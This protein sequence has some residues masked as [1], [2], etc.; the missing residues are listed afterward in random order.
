MSPTRAQLYD[1]PVPG[2]LAP[3]LSERD[4]VQGRADA[5]FELVM[6]GDFECPF[7]LA[8]QSVLTRVRARL[9]EDLRF[10]FRHFPLDELHPQARRAA[11]AAEAGDAQGAFWEMFDALYALRGRLG[12]RDMLRAARSLG[13]DEGRMAGE[14]ADGTHD[15]RVQEDVETGQASGVRGTPAF[16]VNGVLHTEAFD[17]GSLVAALRGEPAR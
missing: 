6:Y 3:P 4:H 13:L 7:C 17:A 16:F 15:E 9:G 1:R 10:G 2:S 11:A 8:S 12:E 5:P 14:L